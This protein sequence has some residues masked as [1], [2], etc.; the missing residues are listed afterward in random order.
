[1]ITLGFDTSGPWMGAAVLR[2]GAVVATT[3]TD[4]AKGQA[5]ALM[6]MLEDLLAQSDLGWSDLDRIGVGIGP[7]NFTG[8]RLSVSAARGLALG[9]GI[10]AIGVSLLEAL[11]LDGS[12]PMLTVLDARRDQV[13]VQYHG[14]LAEAPLVISMGDMPDA[15]ADLPWAG[16]AMGL[17]GAR[18]SRDVPPQVAIARI[19]SV[20]DP[21]TAPRP[22]PLYLRAADAAPPRE[23]PPVILA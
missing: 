18:I 19:A 9:L 13:Y 15:W 20:T 22:A 6:P 2:E 8:V 1:M 10:P 5:E 21:A 4:L 7:G 16:D 23:K 12:R 3:H 17:A 11:A 14:D